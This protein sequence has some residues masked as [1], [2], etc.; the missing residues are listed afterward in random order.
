M[1]LN[2]KIYYNVFNDVSF[3]S[4]FNSHQRKS[5]WLS[6]HKKHRDNL[7]IEIRFIFI[8]KLFQ[9]T[10]QKFIVLELKRGISWL[11]AIIYSCTVSVRDMQQTICIAMYLLVLQE[12]SHLMGE[13]EEQPSQK[14]LL[15]DFYC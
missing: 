2:F 10:S 9:F 5:L 12:V 8:F 1:G 13:L 6:Q 11:S 7:L 14:I 15:D 3:V 4:S